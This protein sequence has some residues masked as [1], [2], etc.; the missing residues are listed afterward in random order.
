MRLYQPLERFQYNHDTDLSSWIVKDMLIDGHPRLIGQL[1]S[2]PGIFIGPYFYYSLIPFYLASR[3]DPA[4]V[5]GFSLIIS[6]AA[7][8]SVTW[9][10]N[11][12]WGYRVS[13]IGLLIYATS[14]NISQTE[15][16]IVPTAPVFL[17]T[18]W[19]LYAA[20]GLWRGRKSS[21]LILAT[22]GGLVWNI[23]LALG[24]LFPLVFII[25]WKQRSKFTTSDFLLPILVFITLSLPLFVF[26]TRHNFV[27]VRSFINSFSSRAQVTRSYT[28]KIAQVWLYS[29]RNANN[30]FWDKPGGVSIHLLPTILL[31]GFV[32]H[33]SRRFFTPRLLFFISGWLGLTFVFFVLHPINLSEYY[34][35]GLNIVWI[36]IAA[37]SL[38]RLNHKIAW[39]IIAIFVI[40]NIYRLISS[41]VNRSGYVYRQTI[42][43]AIRNDAIARNFPCVAVSYIVTPGNDLGYRYLFWLAGQKL[44]P[45]SSLAPVYT[46]VFPHSLVGRL[47]RTFGALGLIWPEYSRYTPQSIVESCSGADSNLTDPMFGFTK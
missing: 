21:L 19:F 39:A 16:E 28:Q 44:A 14:F 4:G 20:H 43:Q 33:F 6:I 26:E 18:V 23:H 15:R 13:I 27:Q 22:L 5:M 46:I 40:H 10:F 34:L 35:N 30:I 32:I 25:W 31:L 42:V 45:P 37:L 47:D 1:T 17:W 3:M 41:P 29:A 24:L 36:A 38:A 9:V 8:F 11:K 12:L 2:S 7:L